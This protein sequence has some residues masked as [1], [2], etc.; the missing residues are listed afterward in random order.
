MV[1][2]RPEES[3]AELQQVIDGI[4]D[5]TDYGPDSYRT[6]IP[7]TV[8]RL[9]TREV[10]PEVKKNARRH[11]GSYAETIDHTS[12]GWSGQHYRHGLGSDS[13]VVDSHEYGSGRYNTNVSGGF[14]SRAGYRIPGRTNDGPV[15]FTKN[16]QQITVEYVVHPG[17]KPKRFMQ[18]AA[19]SK[20][21]DVAE[22]VADEL[23]DAIERQINL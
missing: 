3:L 13:V 17:V 15:T 11:V 6:T 18:R 2:R 12:L 7:E 1:T 20:A 8:E 19:E 4:D 21:D 22:D 23:M 5:F 16:G 9:F 14:S 10:L